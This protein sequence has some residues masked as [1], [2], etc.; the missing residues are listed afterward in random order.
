MV[1]ASIPKATAAAA[2]IAITRGLDEDVPG[3]DFIGALIATL[4]KLPSE[5]LTFHTSMP[6]T[7]ASVNSFDPVL[8]GGPA[9]TR[10]RESSAPARSSISM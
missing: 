7:I 9:C 10:R 3:T 4:S 8:G 1:M 5:L 2:A 6:L